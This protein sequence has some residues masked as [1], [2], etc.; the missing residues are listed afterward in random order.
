MVRKLKM[1]P[2]A[3]TYDIQKKKKKRFELATASYQ[4][5]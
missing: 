1:Q 5:P 2:E 4:K 3:T